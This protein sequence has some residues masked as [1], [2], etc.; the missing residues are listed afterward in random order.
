M[1]NRETKKLALLSD[2][3]QAG[4]PFYHCGSGHNLVVVVDLI[5][6][7]CSCLLLGGLDDSCAGGC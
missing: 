2:T 7:A 4:P 5:L 1:P 6:A 3:E